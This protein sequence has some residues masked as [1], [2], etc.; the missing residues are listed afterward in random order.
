MIPVSPSPEIPF[1]DSPVPLG[2]YAFPDNPP[3]IEI[4]DDIPP[5]GVFEFPDDPERNPATTATGVSA[6]PLAVIVSC[7]LA[8]VSRR[9]RLKFEK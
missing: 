6:L 7:G 5:R 9:K 8:I 2:E 4:P 3:M 1:F